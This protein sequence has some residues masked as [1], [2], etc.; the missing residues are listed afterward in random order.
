MRLEADQI[1]VETAESEIPQL[2]AKQIED[3]ALRRGHLICL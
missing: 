3:P 1:E 2:T